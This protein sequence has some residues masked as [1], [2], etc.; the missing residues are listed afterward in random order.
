M[1]QIG[2]PKQMDLS[3]PLSLYCERLG[4]GL[5]AEPLNA[6]SNAGF[7]WF[8]W[9]L[10]SHSESSG[11][12]LAPRLRL[13][14]ALIALV[15]AAS[16]AFHLFATRWAHILDVGF[17]GLFN[18]AY[19]VMFLRVLA[20]WP[21]AQALAAAAGF[22]LLDRTAAVWLPA[23]LL[24]GSGFYLPATATLAALT[25]YAPRIAPAAGRMMLAATL[26]LL[27]AL[28]ARTAD[29]MLCELWPWGTHFVWHLLGAW[30][31]YQ[32]AR[33][34]GRATRRG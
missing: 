26:V 29:R 21:R 5:W 25:V 9:K 1:R 13:L 11:P 22:L 17:I 3:T 10:F 34:L 15:G 6:L 2:D 23:D 19:L 16:L 24:G 20:Q 28:A 8:A 33:A 7:F 12:R 27:V 14:A 30:V 32:L 4:P 18:L 31:P